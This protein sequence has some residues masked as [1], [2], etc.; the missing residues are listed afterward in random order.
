MPL[1]DAKCRGAK[2]TEKTQKLSDGG[3]LFL[4]VQP[5]GS[6]LWRCAYRWDGKQRLAAFGRYPDVPLV[7][8]R[9]KRADLK[10]QLAAGAD[11]AK[12]T[13]GT[14]PVEHSFK[15]VAE[16]WFKANEA[17]WVQSYSIRLWNRLR[18]DAFP[19]FGERDIRAITP[20]EVLAALRKIEDRNAIEMAKRV[21]FAISAVFRFAIAEGKCSNDPTTAL[22]VALKAAPEPKRRAALPASELGD[23][24]L[25]LARYTGTRQTALGVKLVVHTAVRTAELRLAEWS[26]FQDD[27]WAIPGSRMKMGKDHLVPLTSQAKD[28]LVELNEIS[29]NSRWVLPGERGYKPVSENTLLY[30]LYRMG[31]HSRA[32]IHGFRASFSTIANES[33]LWSPDAIERQLAHV[34]QNQVRN[35][36]NRA[37]YLPE[38]TRLMAWWSEWLDAAERRANENDFSDLL[39]PAK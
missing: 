38:R 18:D 31:Y 20:A 3:G 8:A 39:A 9:R 16:A 2:P 1:T 28:I 35:A 34:P 24:M 7:E 25:T 6:K 17:K 15:D 14:P 29:G 27:M 12:A 32:S 22:N 13:D 36:Y 5:N 26:E 11:P 23:F 10:D 33:G 37:E 19:D 21:R 4:Q 30:A